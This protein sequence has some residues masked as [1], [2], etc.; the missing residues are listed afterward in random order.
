MLVWKSI[1]T[2]AVISLLVGTPFAANENASDLPNTLAATFALIGAAAFFVGL[3]PADGDYSDLIEW[4]LR[5]A[6]AFAALGAG[7]F[8]LDI[9]TKSDE[10]G[11]LS[12]VVAVAVLVI[13]AVALTPV[14]AVFLRV[15]YSDDRGN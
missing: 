2:L 1:L 15:P 12:Y 10:I 3:V 9:G 11:N 14:L 7:W 8:W 13:M 6:G 5:L 4:F